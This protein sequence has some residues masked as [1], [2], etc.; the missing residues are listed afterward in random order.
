M[1]EKLL[2]YLKGRHRGDLIE[3]V[4]Q[5]VDHEILCLSFFTRTF[6]GIHQPHWGNTDHYRIK[7][8]F[9]SCAV[10]IHRSS[11]SNG[12]TIDH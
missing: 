2:A 8:N 12:Q 9:L 6:L 1:V 11:L 4:A 10:E 5:L 7:D 3:F